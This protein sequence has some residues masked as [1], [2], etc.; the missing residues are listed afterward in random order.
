MPRRKKMKTLRDFLLNCQNNTEIF[1]FESQEDA[2]F[3]GNQLKKLAQEE[4]GADS[5]FDLQMFDVKITVRTV[6]LFLCQPELVC[7]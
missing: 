4:E 1:T 5:I 7:C 6:R 2:D 3:F